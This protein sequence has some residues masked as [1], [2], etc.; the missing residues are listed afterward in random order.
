ML[1]LQGQKDG[2]EV[3]LCTLDIL[4]TWTRFVI[5]N[6]SILLPSLERIHRFY[7][8]F[9]FGMEIHTSTLVR[10]Y[11]LGNIQIHLDR[12]LGAVTIPF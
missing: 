3:R 8:S 6:C 7:L 5:A 9:V 10:R 1:S 2:S 4:K 12:E 11:F